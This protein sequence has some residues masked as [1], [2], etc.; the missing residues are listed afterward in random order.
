VHPFEAGD[1][2][3]LERLVGRADEAMYAQKRCR[4]GAAA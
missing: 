4:N 1:R 2:T 3:P